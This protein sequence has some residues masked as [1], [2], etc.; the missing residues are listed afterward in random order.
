MSPRRLD[1]W[2]DPVGKTPMTFRTAGKDSPK[3]GG[4]TDIQ[5]HGNSVGWVKTPRTTSDIVVW[6]VRRGAQAHR[7]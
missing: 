6:A 2:H 1:G 4:R 5:R 7:R 3:S